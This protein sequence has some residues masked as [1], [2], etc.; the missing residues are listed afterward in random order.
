LPHNDCDGPPDDH[1]SAIGEPVRR[2]GDRGTGRLFDN[3]DDGV[4]YDQ[5][6]DDDT[7]MRRALSDSDDGNGATTDDDG[8]P[9]IDGTPGL[10]R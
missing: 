3:H 8:S 4:T 9:D 1:D 2:P 6:T 7:A 5:R 10:S